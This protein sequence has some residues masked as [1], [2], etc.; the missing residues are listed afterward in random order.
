VKHKSNSKLILDVVSLWD[1]ICKRGLE[2]GKEGRDRALLDELKWRLKLEKGNI[3]KQL[4]QVK[5]EEFVYTFFGIV[6]PFAKMY[7]EIY[8]LM[9]KF[10]ARRAKENILVKFDFSFRDGK[11]EFDINKFKDS[12]EVLQR[13]RKLKIIWT[14]DDL[15][16]LFKLFSIIR[17]GL[18]DMQPINHVDFRI[19]TNFKLPNVP[20]FRG[21]LYE[22]LIKVREAIQ[23]CIELV[24]SESNIDSAHPFWGIY[25]DLTDLVPIFHEIL[26]QGSARLENIEPHKAKEAIDYFEKEIWSKLQFRITEE[27]VKELLDVLNLPFWKYR[28]YLYEVWATMHTID[29]FTD[30][31][32]LFNVDPSGTLTVDRGRTTEIATIST[33]KGNLKFIAQLK[34]PVTGM[35]KRKSIKPD[36]R[37]CIEPMKN[38]GNTLLLVELKQRKKITLKY[39][40]EIINAY[41]VGCP[42]SVKNYFLIYD[43]L[44]SKCNTLTTVK[45]QLIG[46][47]NPSHPELIS[48]YKKDIV[49]NII[50]LGYKPER[51]FD[52]ILFDISSSMTGMY[53]SAEVQEA[54][55]TLLLN[56]I[57]SLI[58]LF[59]TQLIEPK[60]KDPSVIVESLKNTWGM[61][62]LEPC[63]KQL[64]SNFKDIKR[65]LVITDGKYGEAPSLSK[66]EIVQCQP[67]YQE[68]LHI[69][70]KRD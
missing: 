45:S 1:E 43:E 53:D 18:K 44:S 69:L 26:L 4:K 57:Q 52:A 25:V 8:S 50:N 56:N 63:L 38:S 17:A 15:H 40:S 6:E 10:G 62:A 33:D 29:A 65:I 28:W 46:N 54:I 16:K 64:L 47:F 61:T 31:N 5:V 11:L 51:L 14:H 55:K 68:I 58:F 59:N 20:I 39:L 7:V 21:G 36:L 22:V 37:V 12:Y 48:W 70:M 2:P 24:N 19:G 34:T 32:I 13:V 42:R 23:R 60:D 41:E 3:R 9:Q 67:T 35:Q 30:F 49:E 66:F 27:V